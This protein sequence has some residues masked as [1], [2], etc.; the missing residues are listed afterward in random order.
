MLLLIPVQLTGCPAF[1]TGFMTELKLNSTALI[2]NGLEITAKE[3][4]RH[5]HFCNHHLYILNN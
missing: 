5:G 1:F 4:D 2:L 3:P